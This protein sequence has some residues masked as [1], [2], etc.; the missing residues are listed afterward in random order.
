MTPAAPSTRAPSGRKRD[1]L[2]ELCVDALL[3]HC[4][5]PQLVGQVTVW[6]STR[7]RSTAGLASYSDRS[8]ILNAALPLISE[9]EVDRTLRHELAHL[10]AQTRAAHRRI[11]PHGPEWK[12]A[13]RD[14]GLANESRCHHLPL[15]RRSIPRKFLYLC[16]NCGAKVPR[17]KPL[18]RK[19][20]CL[21]CC[22]K[23]NSGRYDSRFRLVLSPQ[24]PSVD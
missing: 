5:C 17:V 11:A 19:E 10:V 23:Y 3:Q 4:E 15:L 12:K 2:L 8:L 14:L 6:W 1:P 20:A 16:P 7:L 21:P 22:R 18:R 9:Q 24:P 13:C